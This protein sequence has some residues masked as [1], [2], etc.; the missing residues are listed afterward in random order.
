MIYTIDLKFGGVEKAIAAFL[1]DTGAGLALIETG[2]HSTLPNLEKGIQTAG[3]QLSDV[4]HVFLTHIHLDHAGAAWYFAKENGANIYVHPFGY[5]HLLKPE[6][7]MNSARQ[8]YQEQMD[9]LWGEMNPIAA[10]QLFA[11]DHEE[12]IKVGNL[13]FKS[14][15][16]PGHAVHHIAWQLDTALFA[17]DVA[18]VK[19][20]N[21]LV[22]PPCPPPDINIED[23]QG[24]IELIKGLELDRIFLTHFGEVRSIATHLDEL[25]SQ[26]L[27]W[28]NWMK[29]HWEAGANVQELTP[30]FQAYVANQLKEAGIVG[31]GL[32][33]YERANPSWM[34]VAGLMR[35]WKKRSEKL[36]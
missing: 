13:S 34:S 35:Y 11:I 21:G 27:D 4:K 29:P 2:P 15:H 33:K 10:N 14:W 19:I 36:Q 30:K 9:S 6:R 28:A 32:E 1:V 25:E 31:E 24:S 23:W 26:L 12:E 20:N 3:Y 22:V 18:G 5:P 17:G 16:T 7:L 8:I